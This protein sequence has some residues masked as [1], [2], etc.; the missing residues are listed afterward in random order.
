MPDD[1]AGCT[2]D[3][4]M[5]KFYVVTEINRLRLPIHQNIL[6]ASPYLIVPMV[7]R[8]QQPARPLPLPAPDIQHQ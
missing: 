8:V 1:M 3:E 5:E 6:A 2:G 4:I 7:Q